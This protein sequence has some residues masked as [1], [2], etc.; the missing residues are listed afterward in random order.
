MMTH[1][2]CFEASILLVEDVPINQVVAEKFLNALGCSV[3]VVE[4]G[5]QALHS[6][7]ENEYD[8]IFMDCRMPV[9]DGYQATAAIRKLE[10]DSRHVPIIALTANSSEEDW[11]TCQESGMDAIITKPFRKRD[12]QQALTRWL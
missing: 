8:L 3:D 10:A 1:I 11:Q 12:L 4:N 6:V 2:F 9:M 7:K 5:E